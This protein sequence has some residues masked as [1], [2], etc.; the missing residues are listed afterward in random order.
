WEAGR[1][2]ADAAW[3]AGRLQAEAQ[4]QV[5]TQT[6][7]AQTLAAQ[8]MV[9]RAAYVSFLAGTDVARQRRHQWLESAGTADATVNRDAYRAA[10]PAVRETLNVI[11][12][13]GPDDVTAAAE[14]LEHSL[15][16]TAPPTRHDQAHRAYLDA[17]RAALT[18]SQ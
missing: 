13:E 4:L 2:Q 12:L 14:A 5:A 6:F 18:S 9:R 11:R 15:Q 8:R 1:R 3:E 10:L 7:E 16:E 17:A